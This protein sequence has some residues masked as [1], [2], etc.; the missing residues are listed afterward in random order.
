[1]GGNMKKVLVYGISGGPGGVET[2]VHNIIVNSDKEKISFDILTF[3][4]NIEYASEYKELGVNVYK[5]TARSENPVKNK[6][7]LK[8]FFEKYAKNYDVVWCNLAELINI[9]ILKMAKKYG[10]KKR[11][12]HSHSVASTRN[13]LLTMLH[14]VN[15]VFIG[16]IATDFWACSLPAGKWF[17]N[18]KIIK[19]K[20]FRVIKNA[21]YPE[22]NLFD[23]DARLSAR[24]AL[25]INDEFVVGHVGRLSIGEKNTL[26]LLETFKEILNLKPNA[27][28]LLVGDGNDRQ[29]VEKEIDRLD[30]KNSVIMTGHRNDVN[31]LMNAM[32][33]F[34]LPSKM[35]GFGIVLIEAQACGLPC[36]TSADVVPSEVQ[37][38]DILQFISLNDTAKHWANEIVSFKYDERCSKTEEIVKAGYSIKEESKRVLGLLVN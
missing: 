19:S 26:F 15:K 25:G 32:D 23:S 21:I 16:K 4:D 5:I 18:D 10:V 12:I 14:R 31:R 3:F 1:M 28:L 29:E 36:F 7:E 33:A 34:V 27:K 24:E 13:K 17:F 11:I 30:I 35:E 38:T 6:Q 9:D 2:V 22:K 20:N 8:D 37:V